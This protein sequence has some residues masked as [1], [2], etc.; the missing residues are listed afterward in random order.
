MAA[1]SFKR[2]EIKVENPEE[3]PAIGHFSSLPNAM[4]LKEIIFGKDDV[5]NL[6]FSDLSSLAKTSR[7]FYQLLDDKI[8]WKELASRVNVHFLDAKTTDDI[9][10]GILEIHLSQ[11]H[12]MNRIT[13]TGP[14]LSL[15]TAPSIERMQE[16]FLAIEKTKCKDFLKVWQKVITGI[17]D[18]LGI[19]LEAQFE[20]NP[21]ELDKMFGSWIEENAAALS[22][23]GALK[24]EGLNL[25]YLPTSIGK[26]TRLTFLFINNNNLQSLPESIG[27][28]TN[29][30]CLLSDNNKLQ[31]I[32]EAFDKLVNLEMIELDDKPL[33]SIPDGLLRRFPELKSRL[34]PDEVTHS[35]SS[36]SFLANTTANNATTIRVT[37]T[38]VALLAVLIIS[39]N[40]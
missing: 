19:P 39:Y 10:S 24:I 9:K 25:N 14:H 34:L 3:N 21:N 37:A 30:V 17:G 7:F 29:L 35:S 23:Y 31:S 2:S 32:P 8:V 5:P 13:M 36:S 1:I 18:P 26:L 16:H 15:K 4:I 40:R 22:S 20:K 12:E 6:D 38:A 33:E 28:L 27:N 11:L